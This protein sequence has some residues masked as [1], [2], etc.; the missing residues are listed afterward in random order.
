MKQKTITLPFKLNGRSLIDN[1]FDLEVCHISKSFSP[2]PAVFLSDIND[3]VSLDHHFGLSTV[4]IIII[5]ISFFYLD[6]LL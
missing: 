3:H 1:H 6:H 2:S 5:N 4:I